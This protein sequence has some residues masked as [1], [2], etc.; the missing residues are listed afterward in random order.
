MRTPVPTESYQLA[1]LMNVQRLFEEGQFTATYKFALLMALVDLA[2]E[3][4]TDD[5]DS[6]PIS[7]DAIAEK[8][9]EYYWR[10]TR[11]Y[12]GTVL[13]QNKGENIALLD[14]LGEVQTQAESLADARRRGVWR[15]LVSRV[16][17]QVRD[18]PLH[19]LQT[20]RG[21][22][23]L[24]FLYEEAVSE[25][26]ICLLPGVA[27]CLRR[28]SGFIR[29]T[30]R[31]GWLNEIRRNA[32]NAYL[33]GSGENLEEFLFGDERVP[34]GKVREILW[35]I[36]SGNC[37]YCGNRLTVASH[38]D[39]FVPFVL[40]PANSAHNLVLAH[41]E[42]NADKSDL[43]A[44][45]PYLE[46]WRLRNEREGDEIAGAMLQRGIVGDLESTTGIARWAYGRASDAGA[47]LWV[48]KGQ[49]RPF[50]HG[51]AFSI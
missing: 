26:E 34:L 46:R 35:P 37:F 11:P 44:D 38:V 8:F 31:Q 36:Q 10:H 16:A 33:V 17:R 24:P 13:H 23:R 40:Y 4:G 45:L 19:R 49:T 12:R 7:L 5:G 51:T 41:A 39:H 27:F 3:R 2:L 25:R 21:G 18:M 29:T 32:R 15:P 9:I 47:L 50:P 30:A 20:L 28:F 6:L 1:F 43:L 22:S 14:W 48:R 42:C